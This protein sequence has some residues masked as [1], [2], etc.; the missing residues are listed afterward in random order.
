LSRFA[1]PASSAREDVSFHGSAQA[2]QEV[3]KMLA[4]ELEDRKTVGLVMLRNP[5]GGQGVF[6]VGGKLPAHLSWPPMCVLSLGEAKR[7]SQTRPCPRR[8]NRRLRAPDRPAPLR[9]RPPPSPRGPWEWAWRVGSPAE[10]R[11]PPIWGPGDA[12]AARGTRP[13]RTWWKRPGRGVPSTWRTPSPETRCGP[14]QPVAPRAGRE[15]FA[16]SLGR[17]RAWAH[18]P[19]RRPSGRRSPRLMRG[20]PRTP[21]LLVQRCP[22]VGDPA[23]L[24]LPPGDPT[25]WWW[26]MSWI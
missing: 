5:H 4:K 16:S 1:Y 26:G 24:S 25:P 3:K 21:P 2:C 17:S 14:R 9:R 19:S 12:H 13:P 23:L 15:A 20:E 18:R 7:P 10:P 22:R 11:R 6:L 8:R